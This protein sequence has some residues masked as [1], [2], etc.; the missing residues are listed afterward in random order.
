MARWSF[1]AHPASVGETYWQHFATALSFGATMLAAGVA[2]LLH[3][4][5]PFLFVR[6]GSTVITQLHQRMV[7][8][9][10]RLPATSSTAPASR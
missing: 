9:R 5:F 4:V 7:V 2:C 3:A 8:N 1:T 6:T 10:S